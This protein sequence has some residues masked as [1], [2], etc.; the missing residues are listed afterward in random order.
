MHE[1]QW[2]TFLAVARDLSF[3]QAAGSLHVTQS[4]V[5]TR[6]R[7]LEE[8]LGIRLFVR[9]T[10]H[11]A[12]TPAGR[13]LWDRFQ[14][15]EELAGEVRD[16]A[17]RVAGRGEAI[18]VGC[19]TSQA[20]LIEPVLRTF[21]A[22][23]PEVPLR[24]RTGHSE[25]VLRWM[26]EGSVDLAVS[27]FALRH[28]AFTTLE[29]YRDRLVLVG[30]QSSQLPDPCPP[31]VWRSLPLVYESWSEEFDAWRRAETQ[32]DLAVVRVD[33]A[34]G[35]FRWIVQGGLFGFTHA[36]LARAYRALLPVRVV[37]FLASFDPPPQT[38]HLA[39]ASAATQRS[40]RL[41]LVE[42][43]RQALSDRT[44]ATA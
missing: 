22:R 35:F 16:V 4:A 10:R 44:G 19:S 14:R 38:V 21:H 15:L 9:S 25:E 43:L 3:S 40:D 11:V 31:S 12:L 8:E 29:L 5:T 34:D 13:A 6:I 17:E 37:A 1:E 26:R 23:R 7:S 39:W 30:P 28:P 33:H 2:R 36:R 20:I 24:L 42:E 27:Y 32:A 41:A 18:S